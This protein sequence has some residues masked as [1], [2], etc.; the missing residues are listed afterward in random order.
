MSPEKN[1]QEVQSSINSRSPNLRPQGSVNIFDG[2]TEETEWIFEFKT[3]NF[4]ILKLSQVKDQFQLTMKVLMTNANINKF[5]VSMSKFSEF[6]QEL[7][8]KYEK[9]HNFFHN[10]EHGL[11]GKNT[12]NFYKSNYIKLQNCFIFGVFILFFFF[13]LWT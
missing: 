5:N 6:W 13:F 9:R 7:R 4:N 8:R 2:L 10:F 1:D 11:N 3:F 12:W